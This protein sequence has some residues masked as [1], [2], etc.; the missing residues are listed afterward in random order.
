MTLQKGFVSALWS[1]P[2]PDGVTMFG[3]DRIDLSV[4]AGA[5]VL[6]VL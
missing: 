6:P 5:K 1:G 4:V 3:R 2:A